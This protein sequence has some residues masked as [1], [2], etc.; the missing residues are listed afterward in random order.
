MFALS[1]AA[2]LNS[3][4]QGGQ[5]HWAFLFSEASLIWP[6]KPFLPSLLFACKAK[7]P[8]RGGYWPYRWILDS[9]GKA[10]RG[11]THQRF[12]CPLCQWLRL[13][14]YNLDSRASEEEVSTSPASTAGTA[15]TAG[16]T[17]S[18]RPYGLI[19]N[20]L[21]LR[22]YGFNTQPANTF[23]SNSAANVFGQRIRARKRPSPWTP[24]YDEEDQVSML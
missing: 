7:W 22:K 16:T 19:R 6:M 11:Q 12:L 18:E 24:G 8:F 13:K 5:L 9:T 2:D 4:V 20:R 14:F 1:K 17:S 15:V 10:C 23:E 3:L 21:N